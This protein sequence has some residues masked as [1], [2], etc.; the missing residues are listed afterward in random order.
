MILLLVFLAK[1][2]TVPTRA[3]GP[4][5]R[6]ASLNQ[7]DSSTDLLELN[8]IFSSNLDYLLYK[9]KFEFRV[10]TKKVETRMEV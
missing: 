7:S 4:T 2:Y 8:L 3:L 10:E 1:S 5:L 9:F 6:V